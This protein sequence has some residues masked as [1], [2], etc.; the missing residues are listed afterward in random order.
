M[1]RF[2]FA[3]ATSPASGASSGTFGPGPPVSSA[4]T[5]A[6]AGFGSGL[7]VAVTLVG[8]LALA[9]LLG[10]AFA[11][12]VAAFVVIVIGLIVL[13]FFAESGPSSVPRSTSSTDAAGATATASGLRP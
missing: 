1:S 5:R 6:L 7:K 2:S 3:T 12:P 4:R 9:A 10:L 11:W 13:S 8:K